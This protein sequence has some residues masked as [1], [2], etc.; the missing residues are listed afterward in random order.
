MVNVMLKKTDKMNNK[1][2][3]LLS[4]EDAVDLLK[5][6]SEK[7]KRKFV[8]TVDVV[9]NLNLDSKQSNQSIRGSVLLPAGTGK[10]VRVV[11]FTPDENLQKEALSAGASLAGMED[12][13]DK[14]NKGF[15]DFDSCV[16]TPDAMR[17][18]SK[19]AKKLGPR[20]LMPNAKN[21]NITKDVGKV[22]KETLKGKVNFKNDKYGIVHMIAGKV[23]F[24]NKDLLSNI[25]A[26]VSAVK[27]A[28]PEGV[29][30]KYMESMYLTT[31][32]GPSVR[33]DLDKI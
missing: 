1:E 23:N 2:M 21:G 16:A 27:E 8:E 17:S 6:N 9:L 5:K 13:M 3:E 20:G 12:L 18:L 15:T 24:D 7:K 22:V 30:G 28:R 10:K 25:K 14:V 29:K 4:L 33:V 26:A 32:M 31:T 19:V 11:V